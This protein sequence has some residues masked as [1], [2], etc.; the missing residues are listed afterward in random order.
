L[1]EKKE[2]K[3]SY[4]GATDIGLV[5]SENQDYFGKFPKDS[6]NIYQPKGILFIVADGM[7]GHRGG[8]EASRSAVE[9]VSREYYSSTS[10]VITNAL[11]YAFKTSNLNI[12][13]SSAGSPQFHKMGT[14]CSAMVFEND[15]AHIAHV[16]D[17]RIYKIADGEI[18]QFTN[19]H[20]EVGE[21]FRKGILSEEEAKHH[22]SKSVLVRAMGIEADI[23]V[24]LI[25]NIA[26]SA[27][28]NFVI[29]SD[30]LAKV[31]T[32]E[33][34]QVVL[35]NSAEEACKKLIALANDCGGKD[36]V[37]VQ[38]IKILDDNVNEIPYK[39]SIT[40]KNKSK[41]NII[42]FTIVLLI[43]LCIA[44]IIYQNKIWNFFSKNSNNNIDSTL[45]NIEPNNPDSEENIITEANIYLST[46]N[47]DSAITLYNFILNENPLHISAL[48][49]KEQVV[50]KYLQKG[51]QLIYEN[52]SDEALLY[53]KKALTL[54]PEDKELENK[55]VSLQKNI[56]KLPFDVKK[57]IEIKSKEKTTQNNLRLPDTKND[58][59][60]NDQSAFMPNN[61]SDWESDGLTEKDFRFTTN[62]FN[63][64]ET[65]RS[66]KLIYKKELND[67]DIEVDLQFDDNSV[68][69]AGII[70]GYTKS[71]NNGNENY[72]LFTLDNS[73]NYTLLKL[74]NR[75]EDLLL[76]GKRQLDLDKKIFSLKIK[77][78]G[79]WVMIYSNN[80]LLESYLSSDF[81]KGRIGLYAE[82]NTRA[83]FTDLKISSAF[84][85]NN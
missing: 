39:K 52:K 71:E 49:G 60:L 72:Y 83:N 13:Q 64:F 1:K 55:I 17:S 12:N 24:D 2:L 77:C 59:V 5:R 85:K 18:I 32:E 48:N 30:G 10:D 67:I 15:L 26:I 27:G 63:F 78:L 81:I 46:G 54:K 6:L 74:S 37:T 11:L 62:G 21:M 9:I 7:G 65:N 58:K 42:Y 14:T 53:F 8:K 31:E 34:K 38:V 25:E 70:V 75:T 51:N 50:L 69:K 16:G 20:T 41:R 45:I 73:G 40:N 68:Y 47:L 76:S 43:L 33:I 3:V 29:C 57:K 22:P 44:A 84:E 28:D 66:K 80:K 79:P 61:V 23:E 82:Q 35:N 36:N 4:Y 56:E 19:D